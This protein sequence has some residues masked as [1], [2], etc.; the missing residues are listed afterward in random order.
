M[1]Q[2]FFMEE[3]GYLAFS[4]TS[5]PGLRPWRPVERS[6]ARMERL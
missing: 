2:L 4:L 6:L 1:G 5:F 3:S